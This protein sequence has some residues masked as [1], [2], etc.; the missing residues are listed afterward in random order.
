LNREKKDIL[1]NAKLEADNYLKDINKK[2]EQ[3]IKGLKESKASTET[4][5]SSQKIISELKERNKKLFS[6]ELEQG[7]INIDLSV[8]DFASIKNTNTTG[9]IVEISEEKKKAG[10]KIGTIKMQ[11]SLNDL[12][13]VRGEKIKESANRQN[14]YSPVIT[15]SVNIRLD[16]RG[17]RSEE[18]E[19]EVIKFIDDAYSGGLDRVEIL[20]GKGTGALKK[21]VKEVLQNHT[22]VK[23]F[24]FAPIEFGGEGITIVELK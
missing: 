20:H 4:I 2:F 15:S 18:A 6:E 21:M 23:N 16:I 1:K 19:F 17:E 7:E 11:V 14:E 3:V 24:Y 13:P 10:L 8:G 22:G 12:I 5:K 9:E